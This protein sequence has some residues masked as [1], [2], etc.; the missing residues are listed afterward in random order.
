MGIERHNRRKAFGALAALALAGGM[1]T[2]A[3]AQ[4]SGYNGFNQSQR[5]WKQMD[6]CKRQ[7]WKEHPDYTREASAERDKQVKHCLEARNAPT[8][9]PLTPHN[10]QEGSGTSR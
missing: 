4:M 8:V 5:V 6:F 7:A 2:A 9:S 1:A 3:S 10:P